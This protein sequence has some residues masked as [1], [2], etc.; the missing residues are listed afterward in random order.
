MK[1]KRWPNS[2]M[3]ASFLVHDNFLRILSYKHVLWANKGPQINLTSLRWFTYERVCT[4][5]RNV[6]PL[7]LLQVGLIRNPHLVYFFFN[8]S[9]QTLPWKVV[10]AKS[11]F[12]LHLQVRPIKVSG[13][14]KR[15]RTNSFA[16]FIGS[17][18]K[19]FVIKTVC[20][21]VLISPFCFITVKRF[22]DH[23]KAQGLVPRSSVKRR[24]TL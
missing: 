12:F 16:H 24:G 18:M 23:W 9:H 4:P 1:L 2:N 3:A 6:W 11:L 21:I 13:W 20:D 5:S 15:R 19:H 10:K 8:S 14:P 7:S 17:G 22:Y